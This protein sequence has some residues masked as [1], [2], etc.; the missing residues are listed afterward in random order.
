[1]S[2]VFEMVHEKDWLALE[3]MVYPGALKGFK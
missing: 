1:V 2:A 3:E